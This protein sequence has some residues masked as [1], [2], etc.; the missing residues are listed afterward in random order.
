MEKI[1][2]KVSWQVSVKQ[3]EAFHLKRLMLGS[4]STRKTAKELNRSVAAVSEDL[5]LSLALRIYPELSELHTK[6]AAL[7][8][9]QRRGKCKN[10]PCGKWAH[11]EIESI[12]KGLQL[13]I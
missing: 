3:I 11:D 12:V 2:K 7:K 6:D 10:Y 5:R 4:W 9:L 8:I 1:P 13:E